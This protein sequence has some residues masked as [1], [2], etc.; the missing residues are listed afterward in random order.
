MNYG[1]ILSTLCNIALIIFLMRWGLNWI[2]LNRVNNTDFFSFETS[3]TFKD[4][5]PIVKH[6][7][8][9]E[10]KFWWSGYD[11]ANLKMISNL[12]SFILYSCLIIII[13]IINFII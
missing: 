6:I 5:F 7:A 13:A 9:S 4:L 12:L 2:L 11:Y 3:Y 8:I 1:E 10:L